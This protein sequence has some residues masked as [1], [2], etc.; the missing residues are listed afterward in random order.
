[1]V[2]Y[3]YR[4]SRLL[5]PGGIPDPEIG[6]VELFLASDREGYVNNIDLPPDPNCLEFNCT[7]TQCVERIGIWSNQALGPLDTEGFFIAG[8][9]DDDNKVTVINVGVA[10]PLTGTPGRSNYALYPQKQGTLELTTPLIPGL[11]YAEVVRVSPTTGEFLLRYYKIQGLPHAQLGIARSLADQTIDTEE[12]AWTIIGMVGASIRPD[13]NVIYRSS[14]ID[15]TVSEYVRRACTGLLELMDPGSLPGR[16]GSIPR[17]VYSL[18]SEADIYGPE[19]EKL[20]ALTEIRVVENCSDC[21]EVGPN[22]KRVSREVRDRSCAAVLLALCIA[23]YGDKAASLAEYLVSR[24]DSRGRMITGWTDAR[25]LSTSLSLN[26]PTASGTI[27]AALAIL[28][29]SRIDRSYL[30]HAHRLIE[31]ARLYYYTSSWGTDAIDITLGALISRVLVDYADT[32]SQTRASL[33]NVIGQAGTV[34]STFLALQLELVGDA[35]LNNTY[36]TLLDDDPTLECGLSLARELSSTSFLGVLDELG[37]LYRNYLYRIDKTMS[38]VRVALPTDFGLFSKTAIRSGNLG[39]ILGALVPSISAAYNKPLVVPTAPT[40]VPVTI[41]GILDWLTGLGY[42]EVYVTEAWREALHVVGNLPAYGSTTLGAGLLGMPRPSACVGVLGRWEERINPAPGGVLVIREGNILGTGIIDDT[43]AVGTL[44]PDDEECDICYWFGI[45]EAPEPW[46]CLAG[47]FDFCGYELSL[48]YC[49]GVLPNRPIKI[50]EVSQFAIY[51]PGVLPNRPIKIIEVNQSV[52]YCA[53]VL[54]NRPIKIIEVN[55]SVIYCPGVLPNRPIKIIEVSQ[56]AIYCPGVLPSRPTEI[57]EVIEI[58]PNAALSI[59]GF[60]ST[61]NSGS[62]Q[63]DIPAGSTILKA[64]LYAASVW[65]LEQVYGVT[66]NGNTLPRESSIILGPDKNQA[67]TLRWDVTS[68]IASAFTGGLQ[69]FSIVENGPASPNLTNDGAA[70]VVAYSNPSTQGFTSVIL[71]GE[72]ATTGDTVQ[73]NFASPYVS[74]DFLVSLAASF[75]RQP[76]AG[77]PQTTIIN[78]T[79][80][81]TNNRLLTSSAGGADDRTTGENSANGNLITVGGIGNNPANVNPNAQPTGTNPDDE[82]YNLALGNIASATPFIQPGDTFLRLTTVNPS[83]DDNI[84][85]LFITS[86]F[87]ISG[88][89]VIPVP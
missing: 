63:T 32:P 14:E 4:L 22:N 19:A 72:L 57:I 86:G 73:F 59:D 9:P 37:P 87:G 88:A 70:L 46:S 50:I 67:I 68:I 18:S 11:P 35:S 45:C 56:S 1:M 31:S 24:I 20:Q 43:P 41:S 7:P 38:R 58:I 27:T 62:I 49:A 8:L 30:P 26:N 17:F 66:F 60:G 39:H 36:R 13:A 3:R 12:L 76:A 78:V 61:T 69:N 48:I 34:S 80:N 74:G 53:G 65:D 54:P 21:I 29:Y 25:P 81:S 15:A 6:E 44:V 89:N 82:Y 42:Q 64:Y 71:D 75:S 47:R 51:C 33:T 55:Q 40:K 10:C 5:I 2:N 84:F 77:Q 28:A 85:G 83:D 79:T 16:R 52:I 23:G